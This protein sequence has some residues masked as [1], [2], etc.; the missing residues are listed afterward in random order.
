M[1]G[2]GC[3]PPDTYVQPL[4]VV[5]GNSLLDYFG[6]R[7]RV[8]ETIEEELLLEDAIDAFSEGIFVDRVVLCHGAVENVL[9]ELLGIVFSTV[10]DAPIGVMEN[11]QV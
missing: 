11:G 8:L 7:H 9:S 3:S 10:L 5:D 4:V 6:K 2:L 1:N